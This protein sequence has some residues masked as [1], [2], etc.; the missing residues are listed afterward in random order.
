MASFQ[1]FKRHDSPP[2]VAES[3]DEL[4]SCR[5]SALP[6]VQ[7]RNDSCDEYWHDEFEE[8]PTRIRTA[9][10]VEAPTGLALARTKSSWKDPG[11]PPD[12]GLVAWTQVALAHLVV[13]NTWGYINSFGVFQIYYGDTLGVPPSAISWLGSLQIFLLFV[14][15]TFSGRLTDAG[16]FR[17]TYAAGSAIQLLGVF[18]TSLSTKYWQLVLAQGICTG[19]GNG[20]MFCPWVSPT[21]THASGYPC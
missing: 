7:E 8:H 18:M 9:D 17:I 5:S 1:E 20:L 15:G 12:G 3:G 2:A 21:S 14:I 4:P 16:Y 13:F 19:L 10:D 11:P 6:S